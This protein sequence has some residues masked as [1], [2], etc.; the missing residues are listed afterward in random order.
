MIFSKAC[1]MRLEKERN[2]KMTKHNST[3]YVENPQLISTTIVECQKR[4]KTFL[5]SD[6]GKPV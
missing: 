1:E 2:R 3:K 6:Y 5:E 4:L